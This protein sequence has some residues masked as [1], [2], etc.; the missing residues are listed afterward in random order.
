MKLQNEIKPSQNGKG[1]MH[2][3]K[4]LDFYPRRGRECVEVFLSLL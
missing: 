3:A 4:S 1:F 2:C